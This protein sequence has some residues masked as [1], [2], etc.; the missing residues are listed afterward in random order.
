MLGKAPGDVRIFV[1]F[2]RIP[3]LAVHEF[4]REFDGEK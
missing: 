1:R 2:A 4:G 3:L